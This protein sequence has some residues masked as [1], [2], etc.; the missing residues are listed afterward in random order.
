MLLTI[1]LAGV[2]FS[3]A[4]VGGFF[5]NPEP[6]LLTR[7]YQAG[8]YYP[9][10]RAHAHLDSKRREPWLFGE[11]YTS[12]IR[13]AVRTRYTFLPFW[14]TLFQEASV[15]GMPIIRPMFT[16]FPEDEAVFGIDDQYMVGDALLV[17]PVT[18]AGV[19]RSTVYFAGSEKWYDIKDYSV[20][21]GPGA[22]EVDSPANKIPVYQRAGTIIP[23][24]ERPRR[25]S[26]AMEND[27]F[28]LMIA[29]DSKGEASGKIYLDDGESFDYESGDYI[30]REF[31]VSK[32]VLRSHDIK[33]A[34]SLAQ[35]KK[36]SEFVQRMGGLRI[37]RLVILGS[38]GLKTVR[39][40]SRTVPVDCVKTAGSYV[41]TVKEPQ[42]AIG[43]DFSLKFE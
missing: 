38:N 11:P 8:I 3:G 26:K 15:D 4:D 25:S 40:G 24:R 12:Q 23:R 18:K 7:W 32:G 6:E 33:P 22:K 14:Y 42:V 29:L 27:P 17:K 34:G 39:V 13:D 31:Q 1:G 36:I 41:C 43:E 37:E 20:E 21:Q 28:T 19:T 30:L 5:G 9:F 10:F 2:P 35:G 16:E